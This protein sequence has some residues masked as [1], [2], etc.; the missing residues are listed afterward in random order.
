MKQFDIV[1]VY[2]PFSDLSE[3]KLRPAVVIAIPGGNNYLLCQITTKKR[4]VHMYE[5]PLARAACNGDI[6]FD[7]N[8]YVDMIFTLHKSVIIKTLGSIADKNVKKQ[9]LLKL[10]QLFH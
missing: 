8:I 3:T 6:R 5:V 10:K 7:S 4:N 9:I 1:L 2:F